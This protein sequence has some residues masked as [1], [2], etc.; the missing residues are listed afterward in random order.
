MPGRRLD[1]LYRLADLLARGRPGGALAGRR[2]AVDQPPD[3]PAL[4]SADRPP[5]QAPGTEDRPAPGGRHRRAEH[6][7]LRP[8]QRFPGLGAAARTV[9]D[10]LVVLPHRRTLGGGLL[11]RR[12]PA[13]PRHGP[14]QRPLPPGQPGRHAARWA[15]GAGPRP[16]GAGAVLRVPG[17]ARP[18]AAGEGFRPA[19]ESRRTC[20]DLR[21]NGSHQRRQAPA[22]ARPGDPQRLRHRAPDPGRTRRHPERADRPQLRHR[23]QPARPGAQRRFFPP[24]NEPS[25]PRTSSRLNWLAAWRMALFTVE[26]D[27]RLPRICPAM[28]PTPD[29][30][31]C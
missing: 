4:Q 12:P 2:A 10:R 3:P 25:R 5:V 26:L 17:T 30:L 15:A 7:R 11:R 29:E 13:R 19:G 1:A 20:A 6:R 22:A 18:A 21:R 16:A 27:S 31:S 28:P 14:V 23:G 8:G 9:G 24:I